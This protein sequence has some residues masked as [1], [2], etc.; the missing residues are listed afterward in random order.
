MRHGAAKL[1][2]ADVSG[3]L[4]VVTLPPDRDDLVERI[5]KLQPGGLTALVERRDLADLPTVRAHAE[6]FVLARL[7]ID[8]L[9]ED[10]VA[11][12]A[13]L[14]RVDSRGPAASCA[15]RLLAHPEL[16]HDALRTLRA[17]AP[18][19]VGELIDDLLDDANDFVLRRR[20]PR[21]LTSCST[22][23]AVDGLILGIADPRFEVR[24]ECGRALMQITDQNRSLAISRAKIIEAIRREIE[25]EK[26]VVQSHTPEF[27]DHLHREESAPMVD[28]LI[29]DR[30][31]RSLEH[32]FT[33]LSLQLEREPLRIAFAAL[34]HED[35]R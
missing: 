5:E 20:I 7:C 23:R 12:R 8:L 22:Q 9:A 34:H 27:D 21:V 35:V 30:V 6:S 32:V 14:E 28:M 15:I 29:R 10:P 13:A 33:I 24:Y 26:R 11:S 18:Q 2:V 31:D 3:G 1:K 16:H 17:I 4:E 19:I 25:L